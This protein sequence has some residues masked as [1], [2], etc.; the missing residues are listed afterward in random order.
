M[1][2]TF[3]EQSQSFTDEQILEKVEASRRRD[4]Y[5]QKQKDF[6]IL[7]KID[8]KTQ[9]AVNAGYRGGMNIGKTSYKDELERTKRAVMGDEM[10]QLDEL[11]KKVAFLESG[12]N[13]KYFKKGSDTYNRKLEESKSALE[14]TMKE[15]DERAKQI[16]DD[17]SMYKGFYDSVY[18]TG[19]Q[20]KKLRMKED[21]ENDVRDAETKDML[22]DNSVIRSAHVGIMQGSK[23]FLSFG[24]RVVDAIA[25][26]NYTD[27]IYRFGDVLEKA[28]SEKD[29]EN[30]NSPTLHRLLRSSIE[31]IVS[32]SALK[33]LG[34]KA[35]GINA[36][37]GIMSANE[38]LTRGKDAGL[39]G[40]DLYGYAAATGT[41]EAGVAM[42]FHKIGRGGFEDIIADPKKLGTQIKPIIQAFAKETKNELQEEEITT[43]LQHVTDNV[44][45]NDSFIDPSRIIQDIADTAATTM[46]TMGLTSSPTMAKAYIAD[47]KREV[48]N[49]VADWASENPDAAKKLV[50]PN[51]NRNDPETPSR[52]EFEAAG[53][54]PMG[55]QDRKA[56]V[57]K[58]AEVFNQNQANPPQTEA[59]HP[60]NAQKG[61]QPPAESPATVADN[62]QVEQQAQQQE[63]KVD[64]AAIEKELQD[65]QAK[66]DDGQE[67]TNEE[68]ARMD[69]I[70]TEIENTQEPTK[71]EMKNLPSSDDFDLQRKLKSESHQQ[72]IQ[73]LVTEEGLS[74]EQATRVAEREAKRS[75]HVRATDTASGWEDARTKDRKENFAEYIKEAQDV[76]SSGQPVILFNMDMHNQGGVNYA[77]GEKTNWIRSDKHVK[78][79]LD[80]VREE[81]EARGGTG[82]WVRS[83]SDEYRAIVQG[84]TE[85]NAR[86]AV[87]AAQKRMYKYASTTKAA[88]GQ[89][90]SEIAHAKYQ[91]D[92]TKR[93]FGVIVGV[94]A[95]DTNQSVSDILSAADEDLEKLKMKGVYGESRSETGTTGTPAPDR[96]AG[97]VSGRNR[98]EDSSQTAEEGTGDRDRGRPG[99]SAARTGNAA[100]KRQQ[101]RETGN[102]LTQEFS[103]T[104]EWGV[105]PDRFQFKRHADSKTGVVEEYRIVGDVNPAALGNFI[106]YEQ[107]D[108]KRFV[109]SGHHR[110]DLIRRNDYDGE[111]ST[112]VLKESDG[113]TPEQAKAFGART[114]ILEGGGKPD[115]YAAFFRYSNL[116]EKEAKEQG[117][118]R[119]DTAKQGFAIGKKACQNLYEL[120]LNGK[121]TAEQAAIIAEGAPNN[122]VVQNAVAQFRMEHKMDTDELAMFVQ[123]QVDRQKKSESE[124]DGNQ[125][126][127]FGGG[128]SSTMLVNS[129]KETKT[130]RKK[131]KELRAEA[132]ALKGAA[133]KPDIL[134]KYGIDVKDPK[135]IQRK[136]DSIL[137]EAEEWES[138]WKHPERAA[139]VRRLAGTDTNIFDSDIDNSPSENAQVSLYESDISQEDGISADPDSNEPNPIMFGMPEMIELLRSAGGVVPKILARLSKR[140]ASGLFRPGGGIELRADIFIG[141]VI[142]SGLVAKD[143][144]D[145]ARL[146]VLARILSEHKDLT[147]QDIEVREEPGKNGKIR[148]TFYRNDEGFAR[149]VLA[150]EIG[151]WV[152]FMPDETFKRGNILGRLAKLT[153]YFKTTIDE[154]PT[155]PSKVL[156]KKDRQEIRRAAEHKV[157]PKPP[158]DE[159]AEL[160]AWRQEVTWVYHGMILNEIESRGL[161]D[162]DAIMI[163]LQLLT[164]WWKPFDPDA[165]SKY[166]AYRYSGVELY[167]DAISVLLN[168][169]AA[170]K[171]RA[172]TFYA[173]FFQYLESNRDIKDAYDALCDGIRIG[174]TGDLMRIRAREGMRRGDEEH[175][176]DLEKIRGNITNIRDTIGSLFADKFYRL[177]RLVN[178]AKKSSLKVKIDPMEAIDFARY[179]GAQIENYANR[180]KELGDFLQENNLNDADLGEYL[181]WMRAL[182]ERSQMANPY[183]GDAAGVKKALAAM[184]ATMG[185]NAIKKLKEAAKMFHEIRKELILSVIK[186]AGIYDKKLTDQIMENE[187]YA[188]FEIVD[189]IDRTHGKGNGAR[190][191]KQIGTLKDVSN[192]VSAT[193]ATDISLL[194][195][196]N[197]N[198]ARMATVDAYKELDADNITEAEKVWNGRTYT[199]KESSESGKGLITFMRDGKME[200]YYIPESIAS[201][202]TTEYNEDYGLFVKFLQLTAAPSRMWF[203]N[204]R[205]G[206]QI[207]NTLVRDPLRSI[208]NL[209]GLGRKPWQMYSHLIKSMSA[210]AREGFGGQPDSILAEMRKGGL[211]VSYANISGLDDHDTQTERILAKHATDGLWDT[212]IANPLKKWF[213]TMLLVGNI[214]EQSNK[215]A[216]YVYLKENQKTL[217][218]TDEYI[219]HAV[220]H[221][222]G[223]PS[224][225]TGGSATPIT[226][227]LLLFSNAAIQGWRGDIDAFKADPKAVAL[228]TAMYSLLPKAMKW[229]FSSGAMVAMLVGLGADDDDYIVQW[230]KS[231]KKLYDGISEFDMTNYLCIPLGMTP[232]GKTAYIRIPQDE[233]GR[234]VGG[235]FYKLMSGESGIYDSA[236]SAARYMADQGPGFNPML[237]IASEVLTYMSGSNPYDDFR[238]RNAVPDLEF[239]AGGVESH[240]AFGKHLWNKYGGSFIFKFDTDNPAVVKSQ[241][242]NFLQ[243]P[244]MGDL[245]GRF[246][247]VSDYGLTEKAEKAKKAAESEKAKNTLSVREAVK[248]EM[249]GEKLSDEDKDL[250]L[251]ESRYADNYRD[252][253]NVR[254]GEQVQRLVDMGKTPQEKKAIL[255][256]LFGEDSNDQAVKDARDTLYSRQVYLAGSP[257]ATR[258]KGESEDDFKKRAGARKKEQEEALNLLIASGVSE[259]EVAD[260]MKKEGKRVGL[261]TA[262]YY[263]GRL[264]AFGKRVIRA[265]KALRD[266][267]NE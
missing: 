196:V 186:D 228:K 237:E 46:M 189:Y 94:R 224:F 159:E 226:N 240:K 185:P 136:I 7:M 128:E 183:A 5:L 127:L 53:L 192:P 37:F 252:S 210:T 177:K 216:A 50:E 4:E 17:F 111:V 105:D 77:E 75:L 112:T 247:K 1:T 79:M 95:I 40:A 132:S 262:M 190:I 15:R 194:R 123:Y 58:V 44:A 35:M 232:N 48:M 178:R 223:S 84:L 59:N 148:L 83:G 69:E 155:D 6:D 91:D 90:L 47:K 254:G 101:D 89:Y 8:P 71:K 18:E 212:K 207:V 139:E 66:Q 171:K 118:L 218:L 16:D 152:D 256:K 234:V 131:A 120:F 250:L 258:N 102:P 108:G 199:F 198:V 229:S 209:P 215:R 168:N 222:A 157:G 213:S 39:T 221:W 261:K 113:W 67:L 22:P 19:V 201:A 176:V 208:K 119:L 184:E 238:E 93:G 243:L 30:G 233:T 65:L 244:F 156:T 115:D 211:L 100:S 103:S 219:A 33:G 170:L 125:G 138:F 257:D 264:T 135:A 57:E 13:A 106:V 25:G 140:M 188:T 86:E 126:D 169:P 249:S 110:L 80:F 193:M 145:A 134:A 97:R 181:M 267:Q 220:R 45:L 38:A 121:I 29:I 61:E 158:K 107:A 143:K 248:R 187:Y 174:A 64:V 14:A 117:L 153:S 72:H 179:S 2:A 147:E 60:Q 32:A 20:H 200:G 9:I 235:L 146:E 36:G 263:E 122:D 56:F 265:K 73:E 24:A 217:G 230:A 203:T 129:A 52:A 164:D 231:M 124:P 87:A 266:R 27:D 43:I 68:L 225:V 55:G 161:I 54:P 3:D 142:D 133:N 246:I 78:S 162:R 51:E 227:N 151:H 239:K 114:N 195:S 28:A 191:I 21:G 34:A 81:A 259:D 204:I 163:E 137:Q 26:T 141:P 23:G 150:H 31:S 241:I 245:A 205:P 214:G 165:D 11:N 12:G 76:A 206:F 92:L 109:V 144:V 104:D 10:R 197:W 180:M 62:A 130:A 116:T 253:L 85:A 172:P 166:T 49:N 88:N 202:F 260:L 70:Q 98:S 173:S 74:I 63:P 175:R 182:N 82:R 255:D 236:K 242:E 154:K 251:R 149:R 99:T 96:Q 160:V 167:A 42:L 41:I